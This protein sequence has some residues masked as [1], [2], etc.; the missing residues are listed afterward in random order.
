MRRKDFLQE[1]VKHIK[2]SGKLCVNQLIQQFHNAGSFGAGRLSDACDAYERM[3]R[4]KECTVFLALAG[5]MVP[6]GMRSLIADLIRE[7]L[8]DVVVS[9][10]AN[11]VH[12]AIEA[13]GGHHYK[14]L[15]AVDDY[16]LYRYHI[17][18]IYDVFVPEEDFTRLDYKLVE[19]FDEIASEYAGKTLSS[20]EFAWELGKRLDDPNSILR[21]AYETKTPLFLPAVRDSEFGFIHWIHASRENCKAPL[22]VDAFKDVPEIVEICKRSPKNGMVVI[23]GGVPR[24]TV[25]SAA[26]ASKKGMDYGVIITMDRPE[27]GGLSGSTLTETVSW[28]KVKGTADK[29]MVFA[30]A[31]IIFPIMVA[32]VIERLGDGFRRK[33]YLK[34]EKLE[35]IGGA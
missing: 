23:G 21:A 25:Q 22:M 1:P 3:L 20:K 28:G 13:L 33:P 10:G 34:R 31:M 15:W 6:A 29:V 14:G 27:T 16:L 12:D 7:K 4:D 8:I 18:R 9:T 17:Y 24:N 2:I 32:S 5:A 35:A 19:I 26:L 30:D 11:M